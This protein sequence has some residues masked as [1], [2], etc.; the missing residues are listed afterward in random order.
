[1]SISEKEEETRQRRENV[2]FKISHE[3]TDSE[4]IFN[5]DIL[6]KRNLEDAVLTF[7]I[8]SEVGE[9]VFRVASDDKNV[10][11]KIVFSEEKYASTPFCR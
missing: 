10:N 6:P 8:N 7:V 1:M 2:D 3:I 4:L 9:I 11:Q 5:L